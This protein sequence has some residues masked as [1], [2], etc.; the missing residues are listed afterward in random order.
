MVSYAP[1]HLV[2]K[3]YLN[4]KSYPATDQSQNSFVENSPF[5]ETHQ[6]TRATAWKILP[7]SN[8]RLWRC[9]P[10]ICQTSNKNKQFN[11][12]FLHRILLVMRMVSL[13]RTKK[14]KVVPEDGPKSIVVMDTK[15]Y[16]KTTKGSPN[17]EL[18]EETKAV[19]EDLHRTHLTLEKSRKSSFSMAIRNRI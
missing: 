7:V 16:L 14:G 6:C 18:I 13:C 11:S 2:I 4:W 19:N 12:R 8:F 3:L 17:S 1:N 10:I 9:Y 5:L 15:M